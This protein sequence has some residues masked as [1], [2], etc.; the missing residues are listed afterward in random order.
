MTEIG[1]PS[2]VREDYHQVLLEV[3]AQCDAH[4]MVFAHEMRMVAF[5]WYATHCRRMGLERDQEI[6][7]PD[8][9]ASNTPGLEILENAMSTKTSCRIIKASNPTHGRFVL[10]HSDPPDLVGENI[11]RS[12][13]DVA[14]LVPL[15]RSQWISIPFGE[16]TFETLKR[17]VSQANGLRKRANPSLK[18]RLVCQKNNDGTMIVRNR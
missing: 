11:E 16:I 2:D 15:G 5:A 14:E 13:P 10:H 4:G 12:G 8:P 9:D 18:M 17:R 3:H 7:V 1:R 6:P